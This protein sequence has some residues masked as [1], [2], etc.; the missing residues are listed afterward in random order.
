MKLRSVFVYALGIII[1]LMASCQGQNSSMKNLKLT[2]DIDSA[3]YAIGILIGEN[4]RATLESSP[5]G[6]E[7]D[8]D[9]LI[10]AARI[11]LTNDDST[12]SL[13]EASNIV[14][15]YFTDATEL[16]GIKNMEEGN[17]FLEAN[18]SREGV[19]TTESG[20]QYEVIEEGDGIKPDE[21]DIVQVHYH[22]TLIDGTV[23]DSS[24]ERGQP[25]SFPLNQVIPGWTEGVQLMSV[26]SKYKFYLPS[27]L[28]YGE[29][30]SG[31]I[32][33]PNTT[34]IFEVELLDVVEEE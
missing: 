5:G 21:N 33:G 4:T 10:E 13:T 20:L 29:M 3:S 15:D 16:Q 22:G 34:L 17:A 14:Q 31:G 8:I 6:E 2:T 7:I 23:F 24:I 26:G 32:I 9:I 11:Y 27:N 12:I 30:G 19:I 1:F 28:A 18:R 25:A